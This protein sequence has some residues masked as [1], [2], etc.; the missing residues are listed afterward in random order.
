MQDPN[1]LVLAS[2]GNLAKVQELLQTQ[3][4]LVNQ[5]GV[6][7]DFGGETPLAAASHT[8]NRAIAAALLAH[9]A[10]HD[11]TTAAFMDDRDRVTAFLRENPQSAAMPGIHDIPLLSFATTA[12][13]AALLIAHGAPVNAMSRAPYQTTPLH[14]AAR[15]GYARVADVLLQHGADATAVDYNGKTPP[16]LASTPEVKAVFRAHDIPVE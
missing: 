2:H 11:L 12:E 4:E 1:A 13:M 3:P 7:P 15:R 16:E 10:V 5:P 8:H 14:G 6:G 9:G